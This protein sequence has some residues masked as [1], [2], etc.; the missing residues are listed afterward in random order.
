MR[1]QLTESH[2]SNKM[3]A[4]YDMFVRLVRANLCHMRRS[5]E[6][7]NTIAGFGVERQ[8]QEG[9]TNKFQSCKSTLTALNVIQLLA[10]GNFADQARLLTLRN[11]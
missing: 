9:T 1:V 2:H 8:P 10:D 5:R 7:R 11:R 4:G 3:A 6:E